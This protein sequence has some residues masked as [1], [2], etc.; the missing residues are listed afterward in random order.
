MPKKS[1]A[2]REEPDK[3]FAILAEHTVF[4]E[5][6]RIYTNIHKSSQA[7]DHANACP[8]VS[9]QP[10]NQLDAMVKTRWWSLFTFLDSFMFN[11]NK[12]E[13]RRYMRDRLK[14]PNVPSELHNLTD[15]LIGNLE[16]AHEVAQGIMKAQLNIEGQ[17]YFTSSIVIPVI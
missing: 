16:R 4:A 13:T 12:P 14:H 10:W 5:L 1:R 8:T 6:M 7:L 17:K 9:G 15:L 2:A 11:M 3:L